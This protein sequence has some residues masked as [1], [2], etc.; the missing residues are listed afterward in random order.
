[1]LGF[2]KPKEIEAAPMGLNIEIWPDKM[3]ARATLTQHGKSRDIEISIPI[4]R[5]ILMA[6]K[7]C[8]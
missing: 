6:L 1:M 3:R 4:I 8:R 7:S 5:M 2:G